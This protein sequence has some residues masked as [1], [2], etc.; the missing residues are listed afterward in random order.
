MICYNIN[1]SLKSLEIDSSYSTDDG[2]NLL[3]SFYNLVLEE[4]TSYDRIT[5]FFSPRV[6]AIAAR[7]FRKCLK[8]RCRIRIITSVFVDDE[9]YEALGEAS[10]FSEVSDAI[11]DFNIDSLHDDLD[12]D[13]LRLFVKLYQ[14]GLLE[15]RVAAIRSGNGIFHEKI[16]IITDRYGDALSFSG[17]NNETASGWINNIEEFKVFKNW[18]TGQDEYFVADRKKFDAYWNNNCSRFKVMSLDDAEK[19]S[20][21][22]R[23][24]TNDL[25]VEEICKKIER[26]EVY[27]SGIEEEKVHKKELRLYQKAAIEH[28]KKKGFR[29]IFEMATG[30]GKTF[31]TVSA[32]RVFKNE[33]RSLHCIIGVPLIALLI[34][35]RD[36]LQS[37]FGDDIKIIVASGSVQKDWKEQIKKLQINSLMSIDENFAILVPYKTFGDSKF[38]AD[39]EDLG[40]K[41]MIFLADEMHNLVTDRCISALN[42]DVYAYRLGLSATPIRLW[43]PEDSQKVISFFGKDSYIFTLER[44]IK[45][46]FLV[47]YNYHIYPVYLTTEEFEDYCVLSKEIGRYNA[48]GEKNNDSNDYSK[49]LM[50]KRARIK[51]NAENKLLVLSNIIDE[52]RKRHVFDRA[53]IYSDNEGYLEKIQKMLQKKNIITSKYTG[54]ESLNERLKITESLRNKNIS[55]IVAIKCLD[56]GVDIP[57]A[58]NAFFVSSNTDPREYVQRLGRVLRLDKESEKKRS[59]IYDFVVLPPKGVSFETIEE[60]RV[61][62]NLVRN[63]II[64]VKYFYSL[65]N[66]KEDAM[67]DAQ[68]IVNGLGMTFTEDELKLNNRQEDEYGDN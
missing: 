54:N 55:A 16:G 52:M 29:A 46:E 58:R 33:K 39:I 48:I 26:N 40:Y 61:A 7:G 65:A 13:Y 23:T 6:F 27:S 3:Y 37:E 63:E 35:W 50:L 14:E 32:L 9:T 47:P 4:A 53:L 67:E 1:M 24:G 31:T 43:R 49:R 68:D 41:D 28:W 30:T 2:D 56:E 12:Y 42:E 22:K 21:I 59:M 15:L 17:S 57:C 5:G 19:N 51:K 34:Q 62:R 36:E 18:I 11:D 44:A 66:N 38:S 8:N 25:T 64:R 60:R 20:L 45:E 10:K